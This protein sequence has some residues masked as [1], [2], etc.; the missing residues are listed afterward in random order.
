MRAG[1]GGHPA[2]PA[3]EAGSAPTTRRSPG[4]LYGSWLPSKEVGAAGRGGS[5]S[6]GAGDPAR[7]RTF[8]VVYRIDD[9]NHEVVVLRVDHRGDIYRAR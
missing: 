2:L 8:R 5:P 1:A 9:D 4:Y 7:P 3:A 6:P